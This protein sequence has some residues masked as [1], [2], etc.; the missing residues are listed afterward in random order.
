MAGMD[1]PIDLDRQAGSMAVKINDET[2]DHLL[3]A[4]VPAAQAVKSLTFA[5]ILSC[6][7]PI[8]SKSVIRIE[9]RL[10]RKL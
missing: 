4:E 8:L 3:A 7:F 6:L 2:S 1:S 10:I 5:R 9:C